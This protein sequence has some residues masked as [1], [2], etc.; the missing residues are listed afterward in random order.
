MITYPRPQTNSQLLKCRI[1]GTMLPSTRDWGRGYVHV[2]YT[3]DWRQARATVIHQGL[4]TGLLSSTRDWR[5]GYCHPPGTGDRAAIH[6]GL[7]RDRLGL[8]SSTRDWG[9]GY[10]PYT[11]QGLETGLPSCTIHQGPETGLPSTRDWR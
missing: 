1:L 6:Q 7:D 5:Q 8:P 10:V 9:R 3:R 2:P 11:M 4:G